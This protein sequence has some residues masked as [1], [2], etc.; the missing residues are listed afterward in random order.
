MKMKKQKNEILKVLS[1]TIKA[2]RQNLNLTQEQLAEKA[3]FHVNYIGGIERGTRNPS[4][5]SLVKIAKALE[6]SPKDL[7]PE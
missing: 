1:Q 2:K 6:I 7:M 5:E 3:G 4:M